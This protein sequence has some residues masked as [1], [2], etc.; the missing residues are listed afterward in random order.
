LSQPTQQGYGTPQ[1]PADYSYPAA[2]VQP[3][4]NGFAIA[5]LIFGI[6][7]GVLFGLL[8]GILGLVKSKKVGGKGKT[9][10]IIAIVLSLLWIAGGSVLVVQALK[11]D[12]GCD[13]AVAAVKDIDT[14]MT[15]DAK[16]P[17][18]LKADI[19]K[20]KT[21]LDAAAAKSTDAAATTAIA[22]LS[23]DFKELLT[24]LDGA[25]P[26]ADLQARVEADGKAVD[27]ACGT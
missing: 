8:F 7:G 22:K 6:I 1:P 4:K 9:M 25:A 20:V 12:P 10:S 13:A 26:A 16:D 24:V 21:D 11:T 5:G 23:A 27:A 2:P 19:Q 18:L 3:Q 14:K 17:A 15:A